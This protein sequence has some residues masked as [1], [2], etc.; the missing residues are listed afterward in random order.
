VEGE[1]WKAWVAVALAGALGGSLAAAETARNAADTAVWSLPSPVPPRVHIVKGLWWEFFGLNE[2]MAELGGAEYTS[3]HHGGHGTWRIRGF[4]DTPESLM[5]QNLILAANVDAV[6]LG[7]HRFLADFVRHGGGLFLFGGPCAFR[8]DWTNSPLAALLPCTLTGAQ[9]AKADGPLTLAAAE[10]P[11]GALPADLAWTLSPLAFYYHPLEPKP[12]GQVWVRAGG[13]PVLVAGAA[14]AGRV[15]VF[16]VTPEGDPSAEQLGFWEWPDLPRLVAAICRWLIVSPAP[17]S[18]SSADADARRRLDELAVPG[19]DDASRQNAL[20]PLLRHCRDASFARG[21]LA[22]TEAFEESPPRDF[23]EAAADA[24]RPF[25]DATFAAAARALIQSKDPGKAAMGIRV[26]GM[27]RAPESGAL[28]ERVARLGMDGLGGGGGA[29]GSPLDGLGVR[30]VN[31]DERLRLAAVQ[32]FGDLSDTNRLP[33][34]RDVTREFADKRQKPPDLSDGP[35]L[36]EDIYRHS[37]IARIRL[38]DRTAVREL[39]DL[40]IKN[41]EDLDQYKNAVDDMLPPFPTDTYKIKLRQGYG[42]AAGVHEQRQ[43]E[44]HGVLLSAATSLTP[45]I[46][47]ELSRRGDPRLTEFGCAA[48]APT[49]ARPL[50]P[51]CAA[52]LMLLLTEGKQPDLARL[53]FRLIAQARDPGLLE[54]ARA[55]AVNLASRPDPASARLALCLL[56]DLPA[57]ARDKTLAAA[58][59]HPDESVRRTAGGYP[60]PAR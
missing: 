41:E 19:G 57:D 13:H 60:S 54:Q 4:P 1:G 2:A 58:R 26:L 23:T 34:L 53:A 45:A 22:A 31:A 20:R 12:N 27:S 24:V 32:A 8:R 52:A 10:P 3:S 36:K 47:S 39:F 16:G 15:A 25:V 50:A 46:V 14:G 55:A 9:R 38:G 6:S 42:E 40:V 28:L 35:A 11:P 43:R 49:P 33:V 18:A 17:S 29:E 56:P 44:I 37:V 48:L 51:P 7:R 30:A 5:R 21:I 59:N